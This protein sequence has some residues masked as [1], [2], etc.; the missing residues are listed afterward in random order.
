MQEDSLNVVQNWL[1]YDQSLI[2]TIGENYY[3]NGGLKVYS[4]KDGTPIPNE[5]TNSYPHALALVKVI[6]EFI[7]EKNPKD[8]LKILDAGSGSGIFARHFLLAARQENILDKVEILLAD[9]SKSALEEIKKKNILKEFSENKNYKL[10]ELDLFNLDQCKTLAGESYQLKNL[11]LVILNYIYDSLPMI[12]LRPSIESNTTYEKLQ[13]KVLGEAESQSNPLNLNS[14]FIEDRW[15]AYNIEEQNSLQKQYY[16]LLEPGKT[17]HI[18]QIFYSYGSLAITEALGT[19]LSEDG[20]IYAAEMPHHTNYKTCFQVY[21]NSVAHFVN[22]EL[23]TKFVHTKNFSSLVTQDA[24]LQ[25]AFY[26]KNPEIFKSLDS[27]LQKLFIDSNLTDLYADL[28]QCLSVISS[29]HSKELNK[30]L[31]DKLLELDPYSCF[32]YMA[33]ASY[34]QRHKETQLADEMYKQAYKLDY[35]GDFS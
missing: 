8:T 1:D 18:G 11:S 22:I 14:L 15:Q 27:T 13:F 25:H 21:G 10:L 9:Y 2:S 12:V 28:R 35:L 16:S 4:N 6:K 24:I 23:I 17:N 20:F 19:K 32:S 29:P 3:K 7:N 33:R 31:L 5:I 34:H 26:F 30:F